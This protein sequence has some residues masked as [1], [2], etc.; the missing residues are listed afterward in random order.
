[1]HRPLGEHRRA[2]VSKCG[3]DSS[4]KAARR[5]DAVRKPERQGYCL[6][7]WRGSVKGILEGNRVGTDLEMCHGQDQFRN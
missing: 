5:D 4:S 2:N 7:R 1:M 3:R 6:G